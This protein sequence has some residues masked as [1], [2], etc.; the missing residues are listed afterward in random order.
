MSRDLGER[1]RGAVVTWRHNGSGILRCEDREGEVRV[2]NAELVV[3]WTDARDAADDTSANADA[4]ASAK[5][6]G[7]AEQKKPEEKQQEQSGDKKKSVDKKASMRNAP[8]DVRLEDSS[9]SSS[10][11]SSSSSPSSL[12]EGAEVEFC[13][14]TDARGRMTAYHVTRLPRG[15]V[16]FETVLDETVSG[17]VFTEPRAGRPGKIQV[18]ADADQGADKG[19]G[20]GGAGANGARRVL[21]PFSSADF[22]DRRARMREEDRVTF[23]YAVDKVTGRKRP[24]QVAVLPRERSTGSTAGA[25]GGP[26]AASSGAAAGGAADTAAGTGTDPIDGGNGGNNTDAS[27]LTLVPGVDDAEEG[28]IT[29]VKDGYG[30]IRGA[31]KRPD[32]HFHFSVVAVPNGRSVTPF[33]FSF[34]FFLC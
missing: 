7:E 14:D 24:V 20:E 23:K 18:D 33:F 32:V 8:M 11:S 12:R 16:Q 25:G 5:A 34:S 28:V 9:A 6:N 21:V 3:G 10:S 13:I 19:S 15:S 30:F 17:T 27:D 22:A 4:D 29:A 31:A 1:V 2:D 26:A